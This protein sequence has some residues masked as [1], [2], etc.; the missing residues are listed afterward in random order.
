MVVLSRIVSLFAVLLVGALVGKLRMVSDNFRG[1]LTKFLSTI[2]YPFYIF[3]A[4]YSGGYGR[5][6]SIGLTMIKLSFLVY[7][8]EIVLATIFA[9]FWP[10]SEAKRPAY[11]FAMVF[12]NMSFL[13]L[14][15]LEAALGSE[16]V[17]YGA[18]FILF[19][20]IIMWTYGAYLFRGSQDGFKPKKMVT[21]SMIGAFVAV[22]FIILKLS[23]PDMLALPVS[24]IGGLAPPLSMIILGLMLAGMKK[25]DLAEGPL[26]L[27]ASFYRLIVLPLGTYLLLS[28]LGYESYYLYIPVI[29]MAMPV[30]ATGALLASNYGKDYGSITGLIVLSTVLSLITIPLLINFL[31]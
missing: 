8:T 9:R 17:F 30:A 29:I 3:H 11:A 12:P 19:V 26:A 13:G 22:V 28:F 2:T 25:E 5:D 10:V 20:D 16:G 7:G 27:A 14:P 31:V 1:D 4:I 6:L 18:F 23:L 15:V 21:P 24:M